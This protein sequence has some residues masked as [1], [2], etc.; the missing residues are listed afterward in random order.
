MA[1]ALH[2]RKLQHYERLLGSGIT[3]NEQLHTLG[4]RILGKRF[5][6]VYPADTNISLEDGEAIIMNTDNSGSNGTH[7][8]LVFRDNNKT[9]YYDSF[10]RGKKKLNPLWRKYKWINI[11]QTPDQHLK[12]DNCGQRT[13]SILSV[14]KRFGIKG[15]RLI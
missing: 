2:N 1:V 9:Y 6:G 12:E 4:K 5:K 15:V 11:N 3:D 14:F 10:S 7:W 13:L 8:V